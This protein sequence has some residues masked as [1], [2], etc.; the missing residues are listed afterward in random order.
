MRAALALGLACLCPAASVI[1]AQPQFWKIEGARDFLEGDTE[2]LSVDSEGRVRLAPAT[3]ALHDP[4]APYIWSLARDG[5]GT[6]YLGTGNDGKVF[7]VKD[8]KGTLFFDAA[9]LEVHALA[10]GPDH[11]VYAGTSPEGKVYAI[12]EKGKSETFF[13]PSEKYI[14]A[15]AFDAKGNLLVATGAEGRVHRVDKAGKAT[16]IL[17]TSEAHITALASDKAGNVYAGSSPGGILYRLD[18]AGKTFVLHDSA[19]REVK[20]LDLG[21]DGTLYAAVI[22]GKDRDE[23]LR[24]AGPLVLPP[25]T[26]APVG[27][28]T[29]TE[30]FSL[31][32]PPAPTPSPTPKPIDSVR[33]GS[34]KGA[35]LRVP[36]SGEVDTLWTSS[37]EM[38]HSLVSTSDGVLVGTGNKAKLYRVRDDRTWV[39]VAAFPA[40]QITSLYRGAGGEVVLATSNPGRVHEL[41]GG[42]AARGTFTSKPKDTDTVSSWGRVSWEANVPAGTSLEVQTRSGNTGTP[43]STWSD[44]SPFYKRAEGDAIASERARF[45]QIKVALV[46]TG[47]RGPVVDNVTAAYLQRNLRPQLQ[48]ITVHPPGEIFQKPISLTGETEILGLEG[49]PPERPGTAAAAAARSTMPPATA[50]SRKMF[51]KGIQTFSWRADDPNGDTL[52][53]DVYYRPATDTRFRLLRKGVPE[54]VLAWDTSTVPNGRYVVKVTGSDS[55]SNPESLAL[56]GDKESAPFEVDNTPPLVTVTLVSR[57]PARV[58]AVARDDS[59]HVR[60]AEYSVDGGRWEEVHPQDGI[61]DSREETYEFAVEGLTG[62]GPHVVVVRAA[63]LLGNVAT[64]RVDVP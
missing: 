33:P 20:A 47:G 31:A 29:V 54:P 50:Y 11:R 61:N 16:A 46:G 40:E 49:P 27:E 14:W 60:K 58:K 23:P 21:P 41:Q 52:V 62:P 44:W 13:D 48:T 4:E 37:D 28:V 6:V 12:D 10:I 15:L 63:D 55:P 8:G 3:K 43:D 59:S 7:R 38:P 42:P 56:S 30:S 53:Y 1:A 34:N 45:L 36:P 32:V 9:E 39:M 19:Y 25:T 2:G 26:N 35:V 22:D 17:S 64:G 51:Q 5:D 24:S 18:P 57:T